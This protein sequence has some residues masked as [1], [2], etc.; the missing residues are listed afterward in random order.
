MWQ[1]HG[2]VCVS[3]LLKELAGWSGLVRLGSSAQ[4]LVELVTGS[5]LQAR[6]PTSITYHSDVSWTQCAADLAHFPTKIS[7]GIYRVYRAANPP[8]GVA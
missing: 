5:V 8:Y 7:E 2:L 4:S 3:Q 1:S 6:G